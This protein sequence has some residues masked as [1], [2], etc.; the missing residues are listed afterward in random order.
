MCA[1][2]ADA[3]APAPPSLGASRQ[4][5][6]RP[7]PKGASR[8][9]IDAIT[10]R[11]WLG[12]CPRTPEFIRSLREDFGIDGL[13]SVQSDDDLRSMGL[14]WPLMWRFLMARDIAATRVPITDFDD[15]SLGSAL[16]S[17]VAAVQ[18]LHTAGR[19]TY[20]HCSIGV[21][22]S[23]TVAVGWLVRHGGYELEAAIA[24]VQ[25]RRPQVQPNRPVLER[26]LRQGGATD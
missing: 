26:W 25:Q 21:H 16:A 23:S 20:L 13:V 11:L 8:P 19:V 7:P 12:P 9:A 10:E 5:L 22:R 4:R 1:S 14:D 3:A 2:P 18:S 24:L 15:V 17:A 6:K